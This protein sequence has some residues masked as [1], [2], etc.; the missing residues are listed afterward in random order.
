MKTFALHC[1]WTNSII[2]LLYFPQ[3]EDCAVV[4][5]ATVN[6]KKKIETSRRQRKD[7]V[8]DPIYSAIRMSHVE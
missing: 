7:T 5:Y 3:N 8:N 4:Q 1:I 6:F 2:W